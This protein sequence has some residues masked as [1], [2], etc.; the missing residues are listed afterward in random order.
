MVTLHLELSKIVKI[1]NDVEEPQGSIEK[2]PISNNINKKVVYSRS[3]LSMNYH[4]T[5]ATR[6]WCVK[7]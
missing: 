2:V 6:T 1:K 4:N 5:T 7:I 3:R